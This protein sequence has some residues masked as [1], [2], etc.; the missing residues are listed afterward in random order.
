MTTSALDRETIGATRA[1]DPTW[2]DLYRAGGVSALLTTLSYILALVI[3]FTVP[4]TPTAGGAAILEYIATHRSSY[5]VQQALWLLPSVLLI[6]VFLALY[7]ALKGVNKSY[8]AISVVLSIVAWA[9][10]LA[11][12][13]TGGGAPALVVLSD[14]YTAVASDAPRAAL[15]AAAESFIALNSVPSVMGVLE[16]IG[17]LLVSLL[18]LKSVFS[19]RVVYL[20]IVTGAIGIV[21]ETLRPLLG[22]GYAVYGLLLFVWLPLL[23]WQLY[24]LGRV[25]EATYQGTD[26]Q[27]AP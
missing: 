6:I 22:P 5:I 26:N 12:P 7:P 19:Q 20:G 27:P 25:R 15:A 10:T 18:M 14:Q 11:Y 8:A 17:I 23:G 21:C 1:P 4:P 2:R 9:V 24:K 16:A 13:V 3:V